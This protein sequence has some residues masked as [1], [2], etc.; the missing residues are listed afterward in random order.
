MTR[1]SGRRGSFTWLAVLMALFVA[2]LAFVVYSG[3]Q[4]ATRPRAVA[5]AARPAAAPELPATSVGA[6]VASPPPDSAAA[7]VLPAEDPGLPL[8]AEDPGAGLAIQSPDA[9]F[10][11]L[12][13]ALERRDAAAAA[14]YVLA[15]KRA[16]MRSVDEALGELTPLDVQDVRVTKT[17]QRGDKAVLFARALS[18]EITSADGT[19]ADI[20]VVVQLQREAGQWKVF[21]QMWLVNTPP[22]EFQQKAMAWLRGAAEAR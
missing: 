14:R 15:A 4:V 10:R 21:Q 3:V 5:T 17:T 18:P 11:D 22:E 2:V 8:P 9:A 16:E 12:R 7:A 1:A 6:V 20:D 13:V 19:P